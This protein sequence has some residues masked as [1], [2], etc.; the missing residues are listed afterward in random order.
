MLFGGFF[1]AWSNP[2]PP[3][4]TVLQIEA[5]QNEQHHEPSHL[6][7]GRGPDTHG[8]YPSGRE[9][10]MDHLA[11][12]QQ[13]PHPGLAYTASPT[14][15]S[16]RPTFERAPQQVGDS[17]TDS[18]SDHLR[19]SLPAEPPPLH[20]SPRRQANSSRIP[21]PAG[22]EQDTQTHGLKD[23]RQSIPSLPPIVPKGKSLSAPQ[24]KSRERPQFHLPTVMT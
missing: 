2:A 5:Y 11:Y 10:D 16:R 24:P 4:P 18:Y 9:R 6:H 19:H 1:A 8:M 12:T 23:P 22:R 20:A 7:H 3:P 14:T 15:V 17:F 21:L 13:A